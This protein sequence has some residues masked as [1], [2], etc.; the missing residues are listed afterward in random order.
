MDPNQN[1][2]RDVDINPFVQIPLTEQPEENLNEVHEQTQLRQNIE[3]VREN[4]TPVQNEQQIGVDGQQIQIINGN[5]GNEQQPQQDIIVAQQIDFKVERKQGIIVPMRL[6]STEALM[7]LKP[8]PDILQFQHRLKSISPCCGNYWGGQYFE[9]SFF[10]I[11]ILGQLSWKVEFEMPKL[12]FI[13]RFPVTMFYY[14]AS[15]IPQKA[16]TNEENYEKCLCCDN[17]HYFPKT[18][19]KL[20]NEL[21]ELSFQYG[22]GKLYIQGILILEF[23]ES[24]PHFADVYYASQESTMPQMIVYQPDYIGNRLIRVKAQKNKCP[25]HPYSIKGYQSILNCCYRERGFEI[26]GLTQG[27]CQIKNTR[28]KTQACYKTFGCKDVCKCDCCRFSD[29]PNFEIVFQDVTQID[30]L[31]ILICLIHFNMYNEWEWTG[32]KGINLLEQLARILKIMNR[33]E[34]GWRP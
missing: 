3:N 10:D 11:P 28:N 29:Y 34:G 33:A 12:A 26:A 27:T 15:L 9:E 25:E 30:K 31:A 24:N 20:T 14:L 18:N 16:V 5:N 21:I 13:R 17:I 23:Q 6:D 4:Q 32:Y 19:Y 7:L 1:N 8:I 2:N 22:F